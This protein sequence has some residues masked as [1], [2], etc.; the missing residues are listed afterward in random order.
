MEEFIALLSLKRKKEVENFCK[1]WT[2]SSEKFADFISAGMSG[3]LSPYIHTRYHV[4]LEPEHLQPTQEELGKS[5]I[6]NAKRKALKAITKISQ[7]FDERKLISVHI[8]FHSSKKYWHIFYFNQRDTT[9]RNN[10]WDL[11]PHIHY[12]HDTFLNVT[13]DEVVK[14]ISRE[15]PKLP[16]SIHI[17]YD[18]HHNRK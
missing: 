8:F 18:Y 10:H 16:K 12:T 5:G 4:N 6:G 9:D 3:V 7:M 11:G 14:Q 13:L 2:I 17:K 15:K 1:K